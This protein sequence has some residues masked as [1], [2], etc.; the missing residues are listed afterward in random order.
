MPYCLQGPAAD[1]TYV[2]SVLAFTK[3]VAVWCT[4]MGE[5]VSLKQYENHAIHDQN[6]SISYQVSVYRVC[7]LIGMVVL[8]PVFVCFHSPFCK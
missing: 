7:R 6:Y 2:S 4:C 3:I 1:M 8:G 5:V